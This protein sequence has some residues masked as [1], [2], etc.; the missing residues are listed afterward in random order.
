MKES[1]FLTKAVARRIRATNW[2]VAGAAI[3]ALAAF[4]PSKALAQTV[5]LTPGA[6]TNPTGVT[7]TVTAQVTG[8]CSENSGGA[9]SCEG[10]ATAT[11][12]ARPTEIA[13]TFHW[14]TSAASAPLP[15]SPSG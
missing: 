11:R 9:P 7:H 10:P 5:T 15:A 3:L 1:R 13:P 6:A 4:A 2:I 8:I 12:P 14:T